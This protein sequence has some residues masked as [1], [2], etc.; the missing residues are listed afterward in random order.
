ML[1]LPMLLPAARGLAIATLLGAAGFTLAAVSPAAGTTTYTWVGVENNGWS[2]ANNWQGKQAP[3][4]TDLTN[5]VIAYNASSYA[6]PDLNTGY[7]INSLIFNQASNGYDFNIGALT[8]GAGGLTQNS[9][10]A[11]TFDIAVTLGA[12]QTWTLASGAGALAFNKGVKTNGYALTVNAA[13]A[14]GSG[15]ILGGAL[16][17]GGSLIKTDAGTLTLTGTNTYAGTTTISAG[18]LQVGSGGASG[19]LGTNTGTITDNGTLVFDRSDNIT[20]ANVISGTGSLTQLGA[21]T[22]TLSGADTYQGTTTVSAGTLVVGSGGSLTK[23]RVSVGAGATLTI[24]GTGSISLTSPPFN[25]DGTTA[26]PASMTLADS[27]SL[28]VLLYPVFI[29]NKGTGTFTQTGGTF[30]VSGYLYLGYDSGS[31]GSYTLSGT[32]NLSVLAAYIGYKGMGT[33]TQNGGT[34]TVSSSN[35][36]FIGDYSSPPV[37][38]VYHL[39]GGTLTVGQIGENDYKSP[40]S[41]FDFGNTD[42]SA[43]A[44][45]TLRASADSAA[46]I[47][48]IAHAYV[49]GINGAYIDSNGYAITIPQPL[50]RDTRTG[51]FSAGLTKLGAGT[52][53]LTGANTYVGDTTVNAGTLAVAGGGQIGSGTTASAVSSNFNVIG[54]AAASL[55][56]TASAITVSNLSVGNETG[57]GSFAQSGGTFSVFEA[58]VGDGGTGSFTLSGG[59]LSAV[60][61]SVGNASSTGTLTQTGGTHATSFLYLGAQTGDISTY[62][63]RGGVLNSTGGAGS[64]GGTSTFNFNGGALQAGSS[65]TSFMTG[66]SVANVQAGG[67][68]IDTQTYNVTVAQNLLHD[69]TSGAAVLDGGLFKTGTGTLTL[70]GTN[71]YTGGTNVNAGHLALGS[72]GSIGASGDIAVASGATLD[73]PASGTGGLTVG[74]GRTLTDNGLVTGV[75]G[76]TGTLQGTGTVSG[77]LTVNSGG[78]VTDASGTLTVTGA[79]VNN[80]TIRFTDGSTFN[81]SAASSFTNNGV[82]DY[83]TGNVQLPSNFTNGANGVVLT[84]SLVK[85]KS[86]TH[87]ST[88]VTITI[89]GYTGHTYQLQRGSSPTAVAFANLNSAQNGTTGTTLTFTDA[90]PASGQGFYRVVLNP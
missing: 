54:G 2:D 57:G 43:T 1:N 34:F 8:L 71:T 12:A 19:S 89:D 14:T 61:T 31:S 66:L 74:S 84:P 38:A 13:T 69:T 60:I 68:K 56:G 47:S 33:F 55:A 39:N 10:S 76:V 3:P 79:V 59:T 45:G 17:G 16:T 28:S 78:L 6:Y 73:G 58:Y 42:R 15:N 32:G 35:H 90:S 21:G 24:S 82:L 25:V 37:P 53:T 4:A 44:Y 63:L 85:I 7:G 36:L 23:S 20:V 41:E 11:Q 70:T 9:T 67:A 26:S 30:T 50:E 65:T 5:T 64:Y 86:V 75:L 80:G 51:A 81:A 83:I 40:L 77:A 22:L 27:G 52:L 29:G 18:S 62:T 88:A 87:A 46:F 72:A 48:N 49:T